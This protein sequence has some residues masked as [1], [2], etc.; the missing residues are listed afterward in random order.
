MFLKSKQHRLPGHLLASFLFLELILIGNSVQYCRMEMDGTTQHGV[1]KCTSPLLRPSPKLPGE[2]VRKDLSK[3][4]CRYHSDHAVA[5][6]VISTP[7]AGTGELIVV[8]SFHSSWG[9][10]VCQ[11]Y[12]DKTSFA[13]WFYSIWSQHLVDPEHLHYKTG[14]YCCYPLSA[15]HAV[16]TIALLL[17]FYLLYFPLSCTTFTYTHSPLEVW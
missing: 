16:L 7:I 5:K 8:S 14:I 4:C 11:F 13:S 3:R 2:W 9:I 12:K 6:D 10:P 17:R 15:A 1:S